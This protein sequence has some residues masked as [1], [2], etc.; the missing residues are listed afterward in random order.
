[1][2]DVPPVLYKFYPI[3]LSWLPDLFAGRSIKLSSRTSFNDPFDSRAGYQIHVDHPAG[4]TYMH[5]KLKRMGYLP[6]KRL[7]KLRQ[8]QHQSREPPMFSR[9]AVEADLDKVGVLP[10]SETW[11]NM[12]LWSH[13]AKD[14]T[15]ICV[16]FHSH[17]D[18]FGV[19]LKVDYAE[20]FPIITPP[21]DSPET[22]LKKSFLTKAR[23]WEY[24]KEWRVVKRVA[25]HEERMSLRAQYS[26]L[27]EH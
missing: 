2:K 19:A 10:L 27:A 4:K 13:Y 23:C 8:I 16:G 17:I 7:E 15:G 18:I 20:D 14:H 3:E 9:G 22:I 5:N 12:L 25:T 21:F 26:H 1:M 6:A 11:D 24:E